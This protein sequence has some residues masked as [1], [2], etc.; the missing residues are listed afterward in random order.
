[1]KKL[2]DKILHSEE[3]TT[4]FGESLALSLNG[5]TIVALHGDLG[6]GKTTLVKGVIAQLAGVT[7]RNVQSPTFTYLNIY[8]CHP[9][10]YHFYL[11][12]LKGENEFIQLGF[13][14]FLEE[15]GICLIEWADRIGSLL[16]AGTIHVTL[17]Q[18]GEGRRKIDVYKS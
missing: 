5:G 13:L 17:S 12:H 2:Q 16:P 10:I 7:K 18:I 6:A 14:D 8:D 4:Q 11:Y 9:P 3:E 1:M 15:K